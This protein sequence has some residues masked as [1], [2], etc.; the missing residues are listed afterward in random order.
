[1][2]D[3]TTEAEELLQQ[4]KKQKRH[5]SEAATPE[6]S[7]LTVDTVE[8]IKKALLAIED[9]E[10]PENLNIRDERLKALIV[11][12]EDAGELEAAVSALIDQLDY[13]PGVKPPEATQSDL[14]RLL[15][16][17]GLQEGV[18]DYFEDAR[19]ARKRAIEEQATTF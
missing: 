17:V 9:G 15:I 3:D 16:R 14:A 11:G 5:T 13:D 7:D 12:L 10:A 2:T 4:S 6:D 18:P 8:A 1:M 19:E